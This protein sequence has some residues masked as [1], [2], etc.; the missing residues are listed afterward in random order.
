M[1]EKPVIHCGPGREPVTVEL[2]DS[3]SG[4]PPLQATRVTCSADATQLRVSFAC[5]DTNPWATLTEHDAPLWEEEVVEIFLDPVGDGGGYFEIEINPLGTVCDLVLRRVASGWKREF[6]WECAGLVAT[7]ART[8][9]G[10]SAELIVP[11][12]AVVSEP[13][14]RGA[15]W[16]VNFYRID[17]PDGAEGARELSA[18]SPTLA[19]SFHAPER[20]GTLR[21]E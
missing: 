21:F 11:F 13:P 15:E 10:W 18:W 9:T 17:R 12:A 8:P 1:S 16:R 7:A 5:V 2:V 3:I 20:F 14:E 4:T 19:P 6:A